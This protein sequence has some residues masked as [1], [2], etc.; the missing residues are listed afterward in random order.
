MAL[1]RLAC[2]VQGGAT[3]SLDSQTNFGQYSMAMFSMFKFNGTTAWANSLRSTY[4]GLQKILAYQIAGELRVNPGSVESGIYK[5][6]ADTHDAG[7]SGATNDY[8]V[9]RNNANWTLGTPSGAY[10][11]SAGN[12]SSVDYIGNVGSTTFQN[13]W[14]TNAIAKCQ[15]AGVDGIF[16]DNCLGYTNGMVAF[17]PQTGVQYTDATWATAMASFMNNV[18]PQLQA[19]GLYVMS[20][21]FDGSSLA[22][23][24]SV[25]W[26]TIAQKGVNGMMVEQWLV[27]GTVGRLEK[28]ANTDFFSAWSTQPLTA[29]GR[30]KDFHVLAA[31]ANT[32]TTVRTYT[33]GTFLLRWD[34]NTSG[35]SRCWVGNVASDQGTWAATMVDPGTPAY[36]SEEV[37]GAGTVQAALATSLYRRYYSNGIVYVNAH[38][39]TTYTISSYGD[40]RTYYDN[41]GTPVATGWTLAPGTARILTAGGVSFTVPAQSANWFQVA[42]AI[43]GSSGSN[44]T[45]YAVTLDNAVVLNDLIVVACSRSFGSNDLASETVTDN[46]GNTYTQISSTNYDSSDVQSMTL[47]WC[48]VTNPGIPTI[49]GNWP[50]ASNFS[51]MF[52]AA[53]R[54]L[55]YSP[56]LDVSV[57][58]TGSPQRGT[59]A[60]AGTDTVTLSLTT[61]TAGELVVGVFANCSSAATLASGTGYTAASKDEGG[62]NLLEHQIQGAAGAINVTESPS[63]A[64]NYVAVAAAFKST[65]IPA[66]L[67]PARAV[68]NSYYYYS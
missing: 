53:Y 55:G 61:T 60:G 14:A 21:T 29:V 19:A 18:V 20:N 52:A 57:T 45:K 62:G 3:A 48:K 35:N 16:I 50:N 11:A 36:R 49:F 40:S 33:Y 31:M 66:A 1:S 59:V 64:M 58:T 43:P 23:G 68:N 17:N 2:M 10:S 8:W 34:G 51:N 44:I 38:P 28:N 54:K 15:A 13:Q 26:D 32:D 46:L 12:G 47:Y 27:N 22:P 37:D 25:W 56:S 65:Q 42:K 24:D 4:P 7:L 63:G 41:T 30:G 39:T 5:G 67:T 9:L 6:D